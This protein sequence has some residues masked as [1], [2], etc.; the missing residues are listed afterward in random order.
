VDN[1]RMRG[2]A[3]SPERQQCGGG[4]AHHHR[5][6]DND[7]HQ[8][9]HHRGG[10]DAAGGGGGGGGGGG[11]VRRAIEVRQLRPLSWPSPSSAS[12]QLSTSA[13]VDVGH[14]CG[15]STDNDLQI[16]ARY[17]QISADIW[18]RQQISG[19]HVSRYLSCDLIPA[20][21]RNGKGVFRFLF[22]FCEKQN[23]K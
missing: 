14:R 5:N 21:R 3:S 16:S 18:S 13:V 11:V 15:R 23:C 2:G 6:D 10:Y 17:L 12:S 9:G 20:E 19:H 8:R 4:G 1:Q 7:R 22:L